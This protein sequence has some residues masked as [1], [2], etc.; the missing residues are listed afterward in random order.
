MTNPTPTSPFEAIK[1][2]NA[3]G[4]EFWSARD[5]MPLLEYSKWQ[6]FV[7]I[8]EKARTACGNSGLSLADHFTDTSKVIEAG[9]G[10]RRTIVDHHLSRYAC[11]LILQN[12]DP[13][14]QAV[15][16]AQTYFATQAWRR[17]VA[18][19]QKLYEDYGYRGLYN[20]L[21]ENN[22]H[23]C[24]GLNENQS[25]ND[26]MSA[27]EFAANAF[28]ISQTEAKLKRENIYGQERINQVHHEAGQVVRR[29]IADLG[30]TMPEDMPTVDS[31]K[32]IKSKPAQPK[33]LD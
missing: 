9:R 21:S 32:K 20:G 22:I 4:H 8:I 15:A 10:A 5:L 25:I 2:I 29:A 23:G 3:D 30:G 7:G 13:G 33:L 1:Q 6:N 11:Y 26:H 12:A 28:R 16:L 17:E 19:Q 27:A 18:D 24:K 31:I 14:K